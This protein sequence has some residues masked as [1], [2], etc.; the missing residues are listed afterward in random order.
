MVLG[1]GSGKTARRSLTH[2]LKLSRQG[3]CHAP[4]AGPAPSGQPPPAAVETRFTPRL[5]QI[6]AGW[7][8]AVE[9]MIADRGPESLEPKFGQ[10]T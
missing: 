8:A 7:D 9:A 1:K 5:V 3:A 6:E 10:V 4:E 2:L